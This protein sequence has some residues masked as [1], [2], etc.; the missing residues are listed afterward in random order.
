VVE[1]IDGKYVP[2]TFSKYSSVW[3][4]SSNGM[5]FTSNIV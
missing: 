1:R 2:Q 4:G 3:D 5:V